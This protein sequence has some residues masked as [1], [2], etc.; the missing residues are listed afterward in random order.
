MSWDGALLAAPLAEVRHRQGRLVGRLESLGF[1]ARDEAVLQTLTSDAVTTSD[2]EGENLDAQQVRSS[3]ARHLGLDSGALRPADLRVEGIV[4][5][6]LDATGNHDRPLTAE[7]LFAWHTSLF[8][9]GRSTFGKIAAGKWR[10]D[11]TGAMRVVSGSV[12]KEA[13]HFEAPAASRV[14]GEMRAFLE[15]FDADRGIDPVLAAGL[16]H[17]W[18]VT[19]HPFDDGNGRIARAITDMQLA[20]SEKSA[21][22]FYSMSAQIRDERGDYYSIL[23]HT[24]KGSLDVTSWMEWFVGCLGRAIDGAEVKLAGV[25]FKARFWERHRAVPLNDRQRRVLSRML[26]GLE[27]KLTSTKYARLAKCSQDTASRDINALLDHGVLVRGAAGGRSTS[28]DL[29]GG[30]PAGGSGPA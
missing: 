21:Q 29:A 6:L 27:G 19:V 3:V 13:V 9:G 15:W 28:Y 4:E 14:P 2:I 5:V 25:L 7:R 18:F 22:R 16:A 30:D 17:L 11:S 24:Q 1:A 10:D 23:E 26:E 8:P 12:S 20:R